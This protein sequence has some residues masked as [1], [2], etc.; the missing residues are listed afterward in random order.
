MPLRAVG[1]ITIP[2]SDGTVFDHGAFEP[3]TR[4]VFVAHTARHRL[5]VIDHGTF[6]HLASL[7]GFAGAAGVVA[8]EGSVW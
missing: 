6:R 5:E 8:D 7:D 1:S 3:Q 4:R 2:A